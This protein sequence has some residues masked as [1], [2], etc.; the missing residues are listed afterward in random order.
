[1]P[2]T[3]KMYEVRREECLELRSGIYR[4]H[5]VLKRPVIQRKVSLDFLSDRWMYIRLSNQGHHD[6][7]HQ[8]F[9]ELSRANEKE[10]GDERN[11][12]RN[13]Y[14]LEEVVSSSRETG[15]KD[16]HLCTMTIIITY[17]SVR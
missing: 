16:T 6:D 17:T 14:R 1:M 10:D 12:T 13:A 8:L 4:N 7:S 9:A 3:V 5:Q 15:Q 11:M 2:I